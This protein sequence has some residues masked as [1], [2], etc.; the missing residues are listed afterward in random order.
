MCDNSSKQDTSGNTT[1]E[2]QNHLGSDS[3]KSEPVTAGNGQFVRDLGIAKAGLKKTDLPPPTTNPLRS[4]EDDKYFGGWI[5]GGRR[6]FSSSSSYDSLDDDDTSWE[7]SNNSKKD[8]S[9]PNGE[10]VR[11]GDKVTTRTNTKP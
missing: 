10:S 5:L 3:K 9:P 11:P 8:I 1:S 2:T 4:A 7:D 6:R